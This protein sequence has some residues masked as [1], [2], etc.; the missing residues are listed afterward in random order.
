MRIEVLNSDTAISVGESITFEAEIHTNN[1]NINEIEYGWIINSED[2]K[3]HNP[4]T[5]IF[6]ESG[7][8][9]AKFYAIDYF[10]DTLSVKITINVT[11]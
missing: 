3:W 7:I 6:E 5:K 4:T 8:Y 10:N 9:E 2:R 1:P 11:N